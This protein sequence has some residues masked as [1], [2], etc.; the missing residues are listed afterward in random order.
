VIGYS[1]GKKRKLDNRA[2]IEL[3]KDQKAVG[4]EEAHARGKEKQAP[5]IKPPAFDWGIMVSYR[6]ERV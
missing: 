5:Q 6:L 1:Y 4:G 2:A 3:E